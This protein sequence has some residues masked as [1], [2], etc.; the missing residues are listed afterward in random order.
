MTFKLFDVS[1]NRNFY[2]RTTKIR[3]YSHEKH[4]NPHI[5]SLTLIEYNKMRRNRNIK[6]QHLPLRSNKLSGA[7]RMF[8]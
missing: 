3:Q 6:S 4:N 5:N 2:L 7:P 1:L 8:N